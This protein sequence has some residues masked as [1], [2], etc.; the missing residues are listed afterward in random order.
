MTLALIRHGQT[1]WNLA[2]RVQGRSDIPL[3]DTGR[4]QARAAAE[5]LVADAAWDVVV[6]SPLT[7][8]RETATIFAEVLGL[9]MGESYADLVEQNYGDAEGLFVSEL[10]DRW[11]NRDFPNG[12]PDD[13]VGVRGLRA[14][15]RLDTDHRGTRVLAVSHGGFIRRTLSELTGQTFDA[16]PRIENTSVSQLAREEQAWRVLTIAGVPFVQQPQSPTLRPPR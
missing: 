11:P 16:L 14:L 9:P 1:D 10:Q 13:L 12:E 15:E 4:A 3:N 8:A 2:R 7:R 6:S 5:H